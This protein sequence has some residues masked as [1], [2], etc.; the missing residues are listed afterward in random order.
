ML[1]H[2]TKGTNSKIVPIISWGFLRWIPS[3]SFLL[4][5]AFRSSMCLEQNCLASWFDSYLVKNRQ[6]RC[7]S[8]MFST[9]FCCVF[10]GLSPLS[11]SGH[12]WRLWRFETE[13]CHRGEGR[14]LKKVEAVSKQIQICW[15]WVRSQDLH[16]WSPWPT[17][18]GLHH[19]E[20]GM[21]CRC[22]RA[23]LWW[24]QNVQSL[25]S[26]RLECSLFWSNVQAMD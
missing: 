12:V 19:S 2:W 21:P 7:N 18:G 17:Q 14:L 10:R 4:W 22:P 13:I 24:F 8:A 20:S 25:S 9:A 15:A 26:S 16:P 3:I 6:A 5:I 23:G 1:S 11:C